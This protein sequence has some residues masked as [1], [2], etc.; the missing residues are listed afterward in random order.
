MT[1]KEIR[2]LPNKC[3]NLAVKLYETIAGTSLFKYNYKDVLDGQDKY[4]LNE[5][6]Y[7]YLHTGP[8]FILWDIMHKTYSTFDNFSFEER[9]DYKINMYLASGLALCK[10][11]ESLPYTEKDLPFSMTI[12]NTV[13][14][15]KQT[16][17]IIFMSGIEK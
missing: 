14:S 12:A 11:V 2:A 13:A 4:H 15:R 17:T 8:Q 6:I 3:Y 1:E 5:T 7:E 16:S 10:T 9:I